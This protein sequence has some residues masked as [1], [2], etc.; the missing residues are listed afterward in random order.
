MV[1]GAITSSFLGRRFMST[2]SIEGGLRDLG[3]EN[4]L[5]A[6]LTL[7][8]PH[9]GVVQ[10]NIQAALSWMSVCTY[11]NSG[12]LTRTVCI[13]LGAGWAS[14][15]RNFIFLSNHLMACSGAFCARIRPSF[16]SS[17]L[18]TESRSALRA[19]Q[20]TVKAALQVGIRLK[21]PR[22]RRLNDGSSVRP[23]FAQ[24]RQ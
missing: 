2:P 11:T 8:G 3:G 16:A 24:L 4:D 18:M 6:S 12:L 19:S 5:I 21:V 9:V 23:G 13:I 22:T 20:M 1:L 15:F 10:S 14:A 7:D 17:A